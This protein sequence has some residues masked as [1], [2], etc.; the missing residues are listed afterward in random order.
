MAAEPL[1]L[2]VSLGAPPDADADERSRLAYQ[3]LAEA[4]DLE[5]E[6]A[7]LVKGGPAP[8][9]AKAA[10]VV[11]VG[12]VAVVVLPVVLPKLIE[13]LQTWT[14]RGSGRTIKIEVG[15]SKMEFTPDRPLSPDEITRLAEKLAALQT[16]PKQA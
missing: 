2:T 4:K 15:E 1:Q 10:E 11:T 5:V 7:E 16:K 6:S 14:L 13:F 8:E 3:F 12:A 9:G